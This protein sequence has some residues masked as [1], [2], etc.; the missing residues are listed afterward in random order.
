M[1]LSLDHPDLPMRHESPPREAFCARAIV[2]RVRWGTGLSQT[3]FA[4]TFGI[5]L[6][7]LEALE[8]GRAIPDAALLSYLAVIEWSP[9]AVLEALDRAGRAPD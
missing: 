4:A 9:N 2:Q 5:D 3:H 7:A 1:T 8:A 6:E